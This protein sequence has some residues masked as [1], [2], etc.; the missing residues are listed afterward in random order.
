MSLLTTLKNRS[1]IYIT[2]TLLIVFYGIFLV[3]P[4]I[5]ALIGSFYN[6][7]PMVGIFKFNGLTNYKTVLGDS[8]LWKSLLNTLIFTVVVVVLRTSMGL[9]VALGIHFS[10]RFKSY[11]RIS[12]FLPVI[13]SLVSVALVWKW[14]YDPI[15]GSINTFLGMLHIPAIN[16]LQN[17]KLAL[18]S[19]MAMTLWKD[20]GY[21]VV[22]YLAGLAGIPKTYYEAADID[23]ASGFSKLWNIILPLLTG[24]TLFIVLTSMIGYMQIFTQVF[25]MSKG[26]PGIASYTIAYMVYYDA[27]NKFQFGTASAI[28]FMLFIVT[29]IISVFQL[30]LM[31]VDWVY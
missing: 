29:L 27:F 28:S 1:M 24:T 23:G 2:L 4:I 7:N 17:E 13:A 26:G 8:L 3:F 5:Y 12:F 25:I 6:W 22:L 16:W 10:L 9:L 21:S 14:M 31:K 18:P 11:F 15:Y 20:L 30:K 19:I